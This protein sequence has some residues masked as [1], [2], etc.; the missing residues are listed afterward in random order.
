MIIIII[1]TIYNPWQEKYHLQIEK[2]NQIEH[3]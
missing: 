1:T 2:P 3:N